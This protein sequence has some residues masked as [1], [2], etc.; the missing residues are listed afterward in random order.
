[1]DIPKA[2]SSGGSHPNERTEDRGYTCVEQLTEG[3]QS[4]VQAYPGMEAA[5]EFWGFAKPTS[6]FCTNSMGGTNI[7]HP[8]NVNRGAGG[9]ISK[10]IHV[11]LGV[12]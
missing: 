2:D 12:A 7:R 6:E 8:Q 9:R 11:L 3:A 1:M 10:H 4:F 5:S